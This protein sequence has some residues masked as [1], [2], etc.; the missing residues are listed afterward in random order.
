M[1]D[2]KTGVDP[3]SDIDTFWGLKDLCAKVCFKP[4]KNFR[5]C[6]LG[7][8]LVCPWIFS[9]LW[10]KS[11][12]LPRWRPRE[13]STCEA[14]IREQ[15][16]GPEISRYGKS[17]L[18]FGLWPGLGCGKKGSGPILSNFFGYFF[19]NFSWT[20]KKKHFVTL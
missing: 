10:Y 8:F 18:G 5:S 11:S 19:F 6:T 14:Q 2:E 16:S 3:R 7:F 17:I 1:N 15:M 4:L 12:F 20:N 9:G 13:K